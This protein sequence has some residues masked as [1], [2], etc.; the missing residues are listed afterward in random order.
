MKIFS[1]LIYNTVEEGDIMDAF[2]V[3]FR[4]L[5]NEIMPILGAVCLVCVIILLIKLIKAVDSVDVTL[6][7]TH[8]T[9]DL[10][11]QSIEKVQAPLDT[12][13]KI[14]DTVDKAHDATVSAVKDAKDFVTKNASGIKDKVLSFVSD[15]SE[16][17]D[18]LKEPSPEDIIG[19]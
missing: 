9:I 13:A 10:V 4:N 17:E 2:I 11:D 19:G 18:E 1:L 6:L 16:V 5:C 12:V 15:V 14:S 3:A 7:K 8:N